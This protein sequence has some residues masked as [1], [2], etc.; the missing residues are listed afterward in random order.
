MCCGPPGFAGGNGY[1]MISSTLA[2]LPQDNRLRFANYGKGVLLWQSDAD[3][4]R[5]IN[6]RTGPNSFQ[7]VVSA[8]LYWFTDPNESG[9]SRKGF[10][11]QLRRRRGQDAIPRRDGRRTN[12]G[13][14]VRRDRTGRSPSRAPRADGRSSLTRSARRYG[15]R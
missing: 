1:D 8:D 13:V 9:N 2:G 7:Q 10:W 4:A 15:T 11:I 6:G 3:A 12:A 14:G 5:F